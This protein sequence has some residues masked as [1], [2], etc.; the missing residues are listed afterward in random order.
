MYIAIKEFIGY[1]YVMENIGGI[2]HWP[3]QLFRLFGEE[4]FDKWFTKEIRILKIPQ[5]L[6]RKLCSDLGQFPNVFL[7][8]VLSRSS[9]V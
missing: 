9:A 7:A 4:K 8:T 3:I 6:G 2:K 1:Y 5:I